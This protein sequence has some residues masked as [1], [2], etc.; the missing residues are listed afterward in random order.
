L[1]RRSVPAG[2]EGA[3]Q[4][5]T[6]ESLLQA[7]R[8]YRLIQRRTRFGR[9]MHATRLSQRQQ[10]ILRQLRFATPAQLLVQVLP[11]LPQTG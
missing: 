10:Q 9:V 4:R 2:A 5:L 3:E 6:S 11:P 1:Y 8:S 7:F